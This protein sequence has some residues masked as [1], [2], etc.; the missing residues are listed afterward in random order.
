MHARLPRLRPVAVAVMLLLWTAAVRAEE[1][2][3]P[4]QAQLRA[5]ITKSLG[6]L[7]KEGDA[8]MGE[9]D[10]NGCHHMPELLWSHREAK[11]RGFAIDEKLFKEFVEWANSHAKDVGPGREM[12][13]LMK[14]AMPEEPAP[15]L[16]KLILQGQQKDGSWKPAGQFATMQRRG[17]QDATGN[18]ARL[19]LL[20]LATQ[21]TDRDA[22][23]EARRKAAALTAKIDPATSM[24]TLVVR[25][26]YARRF[27]PADEAKALRE[28]VLKLQHADGG[29]ASVIGEET[30]DSLAT[31]QALYMLQQ[32][33]DEASAIA[34]GAAERW[35]LTR[36]RD[37][38]GWSIDITRVSKIDRSAPAKSKS[39]KDATGIYTYW[40]SAWATIGLLQGVPV[41]PDGGN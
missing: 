40:G 39:L 37:D 8:W 30:S 15:E 23:E 5:A 19:F 10:C 18:S 29:W 16:T 21:E 38:G 13:A 24:E 27:G 2:P 1:A 7:Q 14:L 11:R 36:Q 41:V 4:D 34:V 12:T 26:L 22:T 35:L 32:A 20:A 25:A 3:A 6:F 9:H 31:G 33:P 28:E 17:E